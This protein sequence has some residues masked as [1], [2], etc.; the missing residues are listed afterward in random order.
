MEVT[1]DKF[2]RILIPKK[3]RVMF[4]LVPGQLLELFPD[5]EKAE[6]RL[7]PSNKFEATLTQTP[8]GIPF[9]KFQASEKVAFDVAELIKQ[10][11]EERDDKI[12]NW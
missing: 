9:F 7:T 5:K 10:S 4:G 1:I 6:I 11:R 2:G 8:S 3:L 12:M